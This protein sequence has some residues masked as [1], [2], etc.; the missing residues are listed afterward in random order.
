MLKWQ[1]QFLLFY[2]AHTKSIMCIK[3]ICWKTV[4][5]ESI[6]RSWMLFYSILFVNKQEKRLNSN[7]FNTLQI[8]KLYCRLNGFV[9]IEKKKKNQRIIVWD[10]NI[11]ITNC[12]CV[13]VHYCSHTHS[14]CGCYSFVYHFL[15]HLIYYL[16]DWRSIYA[17]HIYF[18][19][20]ICSG[21]I[22]SQIDLFHDQRPK[23]SMFSY[24]MSFMYIHQLY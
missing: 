10:G 13:S 15:F 7:C 22:L 17:I 2:F 11:I 23:P 4:K 1:S 18:M 19:L 20:V 12:V 14:L 9:T 24:C 5:L 3:Y 6:L 21:I 16:C 8:L